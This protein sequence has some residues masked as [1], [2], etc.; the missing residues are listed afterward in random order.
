MLASIVTC[1]IASL[2]TY[3]AVFVLLGILVP[4][5]AMVLGLIFVL[6]EFGLSF[7]P[8]ALNTITV[9]Y[10]LRS[11]AVQLSK[12]EVPVPAQRMVGGASLG[13][14]CLV[15]GLMIGGALALACWFVSRREYIVSRNA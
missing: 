15:L 10:Y 14:S 1:T 6:V 5:R 9:T 8:A 4:A 7:V 2:C 12:I 11:L 3:G 13:G